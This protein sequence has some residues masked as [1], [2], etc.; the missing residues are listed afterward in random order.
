MDVVAWTTQ[1][2]VS[3]E[4]TPGGVC[5]FRGIPYA[6]PPVD[7]LRFRAPQPHPGWSG[8]RPALD[9]QAA[10]PQADL[11]APHFERCS[12]DCLYL[13]VWT[14]SLQ[15]SK[16]PVMVWIHGGGFTTGGSSQELYDGA[17]LAETGVVV[18][19]FNYRLGVLGFGFFSS[20]LAQA[21]D[22]T[23]NAGLL[24]Q[25]AVLEWV[26][27]NIAEFGGDPEQ[28]TLFGG[29]AGA[30]SATDLLTVPRARGLFRRAVM[31]SGAAHHVLAP[32]QAS[33]VTSAFMHALGASA[34]DPSR[35]WT[36]SSAELM[37]AQRACYEQRV[38]RGPD[39]TPSIQPGGTTLM[40]VVDGAVLPSQPLREIARGCARDIELLVGT[41]TEEWNYFLMLAE[42][43]K[44]GLDPAALQNLVDDRVPGHGA[45][46]CQTYLELLGET[47]LRMIYSAIETDRIF[48]VPALRLAD[49]HAQH[50][51]GTFTYL[52]DFP[53]HLLRGAMGAC[54]GL[55][56]PFVFGRLDG[57]F[58][59]TF[60]DSTPEAH[61]LCQHMRAAW[62]Q[63][64][65]TGNPSHP[66]L[67]VWSPYERERQWTMRLGKHCELLDAPMA[68]RRS[69]WH[70]LV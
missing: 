1:G 53:S 11:Y 65:K 28:V 24:D 34:A 54:H 38:L 59:R 68:R 39:E 10:A 8:V 21:Q 43:G 2:R 35:L 13:N 57:A 51:R 31:Q 17:A 46:L 44:P 49:T 20:V 32:D 9:F 64:A 67:G 5:A 25:I 55:E 19:S 30:M 69:I 50:G 29:S 36:A 70:G 48:R 15:A 47:P 14:P 52:F 3:G 27:D 56:L 60:T 42:H 62:S 45:A 22:V 6:Q 40:P 7:A 66:G 37:R 63:F 4:L 16:A 18:V 58:G 41:T 33:Q 61:A 12:E 26:R 23:P